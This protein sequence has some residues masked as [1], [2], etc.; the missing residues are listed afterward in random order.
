MD[1]PTL[2]SPV[3]APPALLLHVRIGTLEVSAESGIEARRVAEAIP[4]ALE[5]RFRT[6]PIPTGRSS[7]SRD[8]VT[9]HADAVADEVFRTARANPQLRDEFR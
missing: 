6:W 1:A 9:R 5:R 3:V 7:W 4:D 8:P 2:E